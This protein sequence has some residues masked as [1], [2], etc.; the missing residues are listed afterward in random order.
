MCVTDDQ[1][2][3]VTELRVQPSRTHRAINFLVDLL[4][5]H[6]VSGYSYYGNEK[7][8]FEKEIWL[9][10]SAE[11][12]AGRWETMSESLG[13]VC[14]LY[15]FVYSVLLC[16]FVWRCQNLKR[17]HFNQ[18]ASRCSL[19]VD[20]SH[21]VTLSSF[22]FSVV[23]EQQTVQNEEENW[24]LRGCVLNKPNRRRWIGWDSY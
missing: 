14:L 19:A 1:I 4:M 9:A 6:N 13:L 15:R 23:H 22:L 20:A 17:K 2:A 5:A 7:Y 16:C 24:R 18:E 11:C 10:W 12:C 8:I 3:S 21:M